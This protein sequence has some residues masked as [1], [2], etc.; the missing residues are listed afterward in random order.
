VA[1]EVLVGIERDAEAKVEAATKEAQAMP[2]PDVATVE[3]QL[4]SDGSAGW[5]S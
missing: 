3:T 1:E 5:R 4:W 2:L